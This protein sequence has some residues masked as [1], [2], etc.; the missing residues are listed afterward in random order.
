M[1]SSRCTPGPRGAIFIV[2]TYIVLSG[3]S[4]IFST[5]EEKISS[6][7]TGQRPRHLIA[8]SSRR[9]LPNPRSITTSNPL[10]VRPRLA[11]RRMNRLVS[12]E[13]VSTHVAE[14][15]LVVEPRRIQ[16]SSVLKSVV[17]V[18]CTDVRP[19]FALPWQM[20]QQESSFS[21]G[22]VIPGQRILTNAHGV[23]WH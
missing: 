11:G 16:S 5:R 21:S 9:S 4:S 22:F 14:P 19:N 1:F 3:I 17:K 7:L 8:S 23:A 6:R 15:D 20:E 2:V 12:R 18:F 13:Q 10:C